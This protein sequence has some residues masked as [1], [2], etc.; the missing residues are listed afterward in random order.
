MTKNSGRAGD[1]AYFSAIVCNI[2]K[3][4][5]FADFFKKLLGVVI[6]NNLAIF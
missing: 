2:S 1:K 4:L 3:T 6:Y 5:I